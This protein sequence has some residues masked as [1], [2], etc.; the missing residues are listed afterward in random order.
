MISLDVGL[1]E[2]F[3]EGLGSQKSGLGS[4]PRSTK[5]CEPLALDCL[6]WDSEGLYLLVGDFNSLSEGLGYIS[7]Q[8]DGNDISEMFGH[9]RTPLQRTRSFPVYGNRTRVRK[10]V[11][12]SIGPSRNWDRRHQHDQSAQSNPR[13]DQN[14]A[15]E[16]PQDQGAENTLKLLHDVMTEE[17][18]VEVSQTG[19]DQVELAGRAESRDGRTRRRA[20]PHDG[21][22]RRRADRRDGEYNHTSIYLAGE[23]TDVMVEL[24]GELTRVMVQLS[25]EWLLCGICSKTGFRA[26]PWFTFG[27]RLCDDKSAFVL[28]VCDFYLIRYKV[29]EVL[30]AYMTCLGMNRATSKGRFGVAYGILVGCVLG[31]F[32]TAVLTVSQ[33]LFSSLSHAPP[34]PLQRTDALA[35]GIGLLLFFFQNYPVFGTWMPAIASATSEPP[36]SLSETFSSSPSS[37]FQLSGMLSGSSLNISSSMSSP[38]ETV[39]SISEKRDIFDGAGVLAGLVG[40]SSRTSSSGKIEKPGNFKAAVDGGEGQD[41][42]GWGLVKRLKRLWLFWIGWF[43]VVMEKRLS[44]TWLILVGSWCT[45]K[46]TNRFI[47]LCASKWW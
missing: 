47:S 5:N 24:A 22:A 23:L 9:D 40:I 1:L 18:G 45:L 46:V 11:L 8:E 17:L 27:L 29:R 15:T 4:R 30:S 19:R 41:K 31:E 13:T 6:G 32:W 28:P 21:S 10:T 39:S 20:Q 43:G 37:V 35:K 7:D 16:G 25:G 26:R 38:H 42:G 3:E 36:S 34:L 44:A 33:I 14:R 12:A 2:K